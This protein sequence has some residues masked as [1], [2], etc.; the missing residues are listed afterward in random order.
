MIRIT[1]THRHEM[2]T[3]GEET[4]PHECCGFLLGAEVDGVKR[5]S[6]VRRAT[7]TRDD[8]PENRFL[9]DPE[10]TLKVERETRQRGLDIVGYYHSHPDAPA[11][12]SRTD[13]DHAWPWVSYLIVSVREGTAH[14]L[15]SW[16]VDSMDD[17][18]R[19]EELEPTAGT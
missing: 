19:E 16:V 13:R 4:Y 5:V 8:S 3:H 7:N 17:P 18:F 10:E 12:P 15:T 14:E 2:A 6:E 1:D 9:I 11:R